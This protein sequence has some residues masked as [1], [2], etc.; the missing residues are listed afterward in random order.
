M[1]AGRRVSRRD[2][3]KRLGTIGTA[4]A[5]GKSAGNTAAQEKSFVVKVFSTKGRTA[6]SIIEH[7][8]EVENKEI[9]LYKLKGT[10][11]ELRDAMFKRSANET[12]TLTPPSEKLKSVLHT[13]MI[14]SANSSLTRDYKI[15]RMMLPSPEDFLT[16]INFLKKGLIKKPIVMHVATID[17]K[18]K[19]IGYVSARF[20]EKFLRN[21][22]I[23]N[24]RMGEVLDEI[25]NTNEN[26]LNTPQRIN[27][28]HG[29]VQRLR[30]FGIIIKT[31]PTKE[32]TTKRGY[33]ERK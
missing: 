12:K 7:Y 25:I 17:E 2:F 14:N 24:P 33:F 32:Y 18:G 31:T 3:L 28:Y 11:G 15:K 22:S 4:I 6:K 10:R 19:L 29:L 23:E 21:Y 13:H 1:A 8:P 5:L 30:E 9:S 20:G 16:L 27:K 26:G